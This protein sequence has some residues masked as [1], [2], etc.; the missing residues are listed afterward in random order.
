VVGKRDLPAI[1]VQ[2]DGD[3]KPGPALSAFHD[4]QRTSKRAHALIHS[5]QA[6]PPWLARR[7]AA[8]II[9]HRDFQSEG[10]LLGIVGAASVDQLLRQ[11]NVDR[12]G[13]AMAFSL[14]IPS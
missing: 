10:P 8:A 1:V 5:R 4:P 12:L 3:F 13:L 2:R 14:V 7:E 9:L 6:E 11:P